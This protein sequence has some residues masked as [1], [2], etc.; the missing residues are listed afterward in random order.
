MG[1]TDGDA[2]RV[3]GGPKADWKKTLLELDLKNIIVACP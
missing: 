3:H 1:D 2:P